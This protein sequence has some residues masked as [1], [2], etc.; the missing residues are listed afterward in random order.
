MTI[1]FILICQVSFAQ[2]FLIS[3]VFA[4]AFGKSRDDKKEWIELYNLSPAI[5]VNEITL[6]IYEDG[7]KPYRTT[8]ATPGI[9]FDKY[10]LIATDLGLG[11]DACLEIEPVIMP[12][13][14]KNIGKKK[15]CVIINEQHSTCA[16]F[17]KKSFMPD[18]VALFRE[19]NDISLEP[20]WRHEPCEF[21]P[22]LFATPGFLARTC[23]LASSNCLKGF[24]R[25]E[26]LEPAVFDL[27]LVPDQSEKVCHIISSA[28]KADEH[29]QKSSH[30]WRKRDFSPISHENTAK[31]ETEA[32]PQVNLQHINGRFIL[33]FEIL[34]AVNLKVLASDLVLQRAFI[35]KG[36]KT[37][38]FAS[39]SEN[40]T[41][42]WSNF[43]KKSSP[44]VI[45]P[46]S[47]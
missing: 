7:E 45:S 12:F 24:M 31:S 10:L 5:K 32:W 6:E 35:E 44:L 3:E 40:I 46:Q 19:L 36:Q 47:N 43:L 25:T 18:G 14:I 22:L 13:S 26:A 34:E 9:I 16:S 4:N 38:E 2:N 15:L 11:I 23:Q 29:E 27:C 28:L 39:H 42:T 17:S 33:Q 41:I 8:L 30:I 37:L 20:L 1:F 21:S